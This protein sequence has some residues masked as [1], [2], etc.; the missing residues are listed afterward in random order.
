MSKFLV[1]IFTI[2]ALVACK[3]Q[4]TDANMS[5]SEVTVAEEEF[6][7]LQG[8][9]IKSVEPLLDAEGSYLWAEISEKAIKYNFGPEKPDLHYTKNVV[10]WN[11][12]TAVFEDGSSIAFEGGKTIFTLKDEIEVT[13]NVV[14][15]KVVCE[16]VK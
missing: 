5:L 1:L 6:I 7:S 4:P 9:T 13:D 12:N 16:I 8:Q 15:R 11:G 3:K 10:N 14:Y 2:L